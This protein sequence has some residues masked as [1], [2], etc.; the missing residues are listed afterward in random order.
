MIKKRQE[1]EEN[2]KYDEIQR[3]KHIEILIK[4]N[5]K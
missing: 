4:K 3:V 1:F 5:G 2:Q